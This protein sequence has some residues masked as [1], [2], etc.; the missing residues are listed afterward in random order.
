LYGRN[1]PVVDAGQKPEDAS[2]IAPLN[3]LT[4]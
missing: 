2:A 3:L 4:L 1:H